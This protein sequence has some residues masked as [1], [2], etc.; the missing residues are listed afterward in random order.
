MTEFKGTPGP[1]RL[2]KGTAGYD[3]FVLGPGE[4]EGVADVISVKDAHLIAAAPDLLAVLGYAVEVLDVDRWRPLLGTEWMGE[5]KAAI[6][7]ALGQ[8]IKEEQ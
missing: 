2:V 7:K 1:W 3:R 6:A 5:A 4:D 8:K